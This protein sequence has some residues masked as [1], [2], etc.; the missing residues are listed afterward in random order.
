MRP[1]AIHHNVIRAVVAEAL[2]T[3]GEHRDFASLKVRAYHAASAARSHL[4]P[5]Q[6]R[7]RLQLIKRVSIGPSAVGAKDGLAS[8]RSE[9]HDAAVPDIAEINTAIASTAGPS[10]KA[11]IVR[12]GEIEPSAR[13]CA[14]KVW[15]GD[16]DLSCHL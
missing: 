2:I 8:I 1:R 7:R 6:L 9:F 4:A 5:S 15:N 12:R 14:G 11:M 13:N 3:L 16:E 10:V